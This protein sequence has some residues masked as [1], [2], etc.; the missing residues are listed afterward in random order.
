M[1][2]EGR[3]MET[4]LELLILSEFFAGVPWCRR[5]AGVPPVLRES[6]EHGK[7]SCIRTERVVC[8]S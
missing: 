7:T 4:A 1:I 3:I 5:T 6:R 8:E 2:G